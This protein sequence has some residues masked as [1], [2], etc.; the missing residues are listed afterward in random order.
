MARSIDPKAHAL[1]LRL[2]DVVYEL[3]DEAGDA[4]F[5]LAGELEELL[6][7]EHKGKVDTLMAGVIRWREQTIR[8]AIKTATLMHGLG[9]FVRKPVLHTVAH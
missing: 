6:P 3:T 4:L 5:G 7:P 8:T 9:R 2:A 1:N